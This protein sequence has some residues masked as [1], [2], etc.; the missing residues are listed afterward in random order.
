MSSSGRA[1][2]RTVPEETGVAAPDDGTAAPAASARVT[3][4][5]GSVI[6]AVS[7]RL[8]PAEPG[9]P[10][11]EVIVS[12]QGDLDLDTAPLAQATVIQALDGAQRVCL[13]LSEVRFFG[14]AGVRVVIAARVHAASLGRE[15]RLAGVQ[16]I[17]ER[18]L[19][20]TGVYPGR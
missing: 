14:A 7:R 6:A 5:D 4:Q 13:D 10:G 2:R 1:P 19:A 9:E 12:I 17:T 8:R 20:L 15:L 16:G 18:V 11:P 3:D